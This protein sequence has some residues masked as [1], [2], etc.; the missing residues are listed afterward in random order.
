MK[1]RTLALTP[2]VL[3]ALTGCVESEDEYYQICTDPNTQI[4]L[5]QSMCDNGDSAVWYFLPD[6]YVVPAV[7]QVASGGSRTR[8]TNVTV[9]VNAPRKG[10]NL[11]P[12]RQ[13]NKAP[14]ANRQQ[15]KVPSVQR[16]VAPRPAPARPA[17]RVR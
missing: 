16:Q 7:G 9:K 3:L 11:Q 1:I 15:N 5:D 10:K 17:T 8:P 2:L 4:R 14:A 13:Q 6:W 12:A